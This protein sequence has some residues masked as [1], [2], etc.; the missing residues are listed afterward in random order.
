MMVSLGKGAG[1]VRVTTGMV[2]C[3]QNTGRWVGTG[4]T[5]LNKGWGMI[6]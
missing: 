5:K 4:K 3:C 6:D 1:R 2:R